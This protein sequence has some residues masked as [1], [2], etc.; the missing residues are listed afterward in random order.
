VVTKAGLTVTSEWQRC[1][2][3]A[4]INRSREYH[5]TSGYQS[6]HTYFRVWIMLITDDPIWLWNAGQQNRVRVMVFNVTLNNIADISWRSV[7]LEEETP[8]EKVTDKFF[9][10]IMLYRAHLVWAGFELTMLVVIGTDC[11]GSCKSNYHMITT[12]KQVMLTLICV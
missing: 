8:R 4:F 5:K 12:A 7:L 3:E 11:I 10:H 9:Y 1:T 2:H 6:F